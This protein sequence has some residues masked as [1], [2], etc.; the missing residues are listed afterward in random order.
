MINAAS[1]DHRAAVEAV[2]C[3]LARL[4]QALTAHQ[5]IQRDRRRCRRQRAVPA[6]LRRRDA[7]CGGSRQAARH[8]IDQMVLAAAAQG[9]CSAERVQQHDLWCRRRPARAQ[10]ADSAAGGAGQ[11]KRRG[12]HRRHRREPLVERAYRGRGGALRT[13]A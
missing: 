12:A 9:A 11:A 2:A 7:I 10:R 5:R 1:S 4:R 13:G 3:W 8:A 6:H